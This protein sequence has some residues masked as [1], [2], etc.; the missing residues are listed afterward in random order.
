MQM[1]SQLEFTS[2]RA[3]SA[4]GHPFDFCSAE[5]ISEG[6]GGTTATVKERK[7]N[8]TAF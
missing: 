6:Q 2:R 1:F 3:G 8:S 7:N 4:S 5:T